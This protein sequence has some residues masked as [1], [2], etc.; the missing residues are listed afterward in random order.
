MRR[1]PDPDGEAFTPYVV[2]VDGDRLLLV[3]GIATTTSG[4]EEPTDAGPV[5]AQILDASGW[6]PI[7]WATSSASPLAIAGPYAAVAAH[8]P[9][10]I[11]LS[12][13]W[14]RARRSATLP[15]E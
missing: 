15:G 9:Q 6:T 3:E 13:T 12:S 10:R 8:Y 14:R 4:D 11:E 1:T 7:A 5:R 2:S